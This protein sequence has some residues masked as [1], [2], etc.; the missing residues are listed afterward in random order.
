VPR[1]TRYINLED[2]G[3]GLSARYFER[4][5]E[6]ARMPSDPHSDL[7]HVPESA[8]GV[9]FLRTETWAVHVLERALADLERLGPHRDHSYSVILDAGCG[10]G[11]SFPLLKDRFAPARIVGVDINPDMI[12]EAQAEAGRHALPVELHCADIA[13]LPLAD[14]SVDLLFC[15][16]TLHHLVAQRETLGE[17]HRVLK[18]GGSLLVAES[19]RAYIHS[20]IIRLLFR[21]PM[22]G[23]ERRIS[24]RP[25]RR[26]FS[27]P[28]VEPPGFRPA[29]TALR[30]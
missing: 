15:P 14:G 8:F 6:K 20:W 11:R 10:N 1:A 9:W 4:I 3:G 7:S 13:H 17:F 23:P 29:R 22:D 12:A 18:P 30:D 26:F 21:H 27:L 28:V 5:P 25:W 19:T 16:Q 2:P 24:H